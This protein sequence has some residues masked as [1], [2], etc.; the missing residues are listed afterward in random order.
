MKAVGRLIYTYFTCTRAQRVFSLVGIIV[1]LISFG[2]LI[3]SP[4]SWSIG[5]LG[6]T[7]VASLFI[8]SSMMPLMFGRM[9]R[10]HMSRSLPGARGKLLAGALITVLIVASSVPVQLVFALKGLPAGR[11]GAPPTAEQI[12]T[13]HHAL[14]QTF[15]I[16]Y[17]ATILLAFWLYVALWFITSKR[18]TMGYLQ[19]LIVIALAILAPTRQIVEPDRLVTWDVT[20]CLATLIAFSVLFLLWPRIAAIAVTRRLATAIR[21]RRNRPTRTQGR[22]IDLLLGTANPWLLAVGQLV[23]VLLAARIGFYSASVWLFYLTIFSTVAG[24][25]AGQAAERSRALWLRGDWS[26]VALFSQVERSFR[27]HNNFV[28]GI[29]LILMVAIGSYANLPVMLLLTGVP[30]LILGTI[31][32]TYLG[33]MI[34]QGLRWSE[35]L[36][37]VGVMLAL[38]AVAVL[39][40]RNSDD[41]WIVAVLE[42]ALAV[43]A[44]TLR[45]VARNR[46][47]HIDWMKCRSDRALSGRSAA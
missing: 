38:M 10:G 13:Y 43:M 40:A 9:A 11:H 47:A 30:L 3:Y 5:L 6:L 2:L 26:T 34:T 22:E 17:S 15:L 46:W 27:R 12:T 36:L 28:L 7:G 33:L 39:A 23:P 1:I 4:V 8:G 25:I 24:A 20:V 41:L 29:L 31:L 35:S 21:D 18:N 19:G 16:T 32:S 42:S 44:L 14:M 37:A 45:Y